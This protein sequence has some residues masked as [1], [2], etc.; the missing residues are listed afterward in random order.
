[1]SDDRKRIMEKGKSPTVLHSHWQRLALI[2]SFNYLLK[3][4]KFLTFIFLQ[5][6]PFNSNYSCFAVQ[7]DVTIFW[8]AAMMD[9]STDVLFTLNKS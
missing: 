7:L 6:D 5:F 9:A 4:G 3:S 2:L 1:M 8:S